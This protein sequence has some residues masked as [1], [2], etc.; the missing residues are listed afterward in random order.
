VSLLYLVLAS[1]AIAGQ[2]NP[3]RAETLAG[4]GFGEALGGAV[5]TGAV[6]ALILSAV[7]VAVLVVAGLL[8]RRAMRMLQ[9]GL[10]TPEIPAAVA[11]LLGILPFVAIV[12]ALIVPFGA[13]IYLAVSSLWSAIERPVLRRVLWSEGEWRPGEREE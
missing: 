6:G 2:A 10:P 9:Q 5:F 11:P 13:A 1:P 3:L 8:Q 7:I 12:P 4:V